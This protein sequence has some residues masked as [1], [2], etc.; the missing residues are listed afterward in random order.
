MD[1]ISTPPP[2][3]LL[4]RLSHGVGISRSRGRHFGRL[5]RTGGDTVGHRSR[6]RAGLRSGSAGADPPRR[7]RSTS[8][9]R[10]VDLTVVERSPGALSSWIARG[11]SRAADATARAARVAGPLPRASSASAWAV[12]QYE[13]YLRELLA[14][15]SRDALPTL[16]VEDVHVGTCSRGYRRFRMW[17]EWP[18]SCGG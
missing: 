12:A 8:S 4:R 6:I 7:K 13:G 16:E 11:D 15:L 14:R 18:A 10:G 1:R 3:R 17:A 9:P 5:P 2:R